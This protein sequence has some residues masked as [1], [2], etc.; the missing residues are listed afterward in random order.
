[1]HAWRARA[2]VT[3]MRTDQL[4]T[5]AC[6]MLPISDPDRSDSDVDVDAYARA[7]STAFFFLRFRSSLR[8]VKTGGALAALQSTRHAAARG[9]RATVTSMKRP[10]SSLCKRPSGGAHRPARRRRRGRQRWR[11][12]HDPRRPGPPAHGQN[13]ARAQGALEY[14]LARSNAKPKMARV[15]RVRCVSV[16]A[17][18]CVCVCARVCV[19]VKTS[20]ALMS[21]GACECVGGV[22]P[23]CLHV[24]VRDYV[25]TRVHV[26]L[27]KSSAASSLGRC[28]RARE[29]TLLRLRGAHQMQ[30]GG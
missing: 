24:H 6:A 23:L 15:L 30:R 2:R 22:R 26:P 5:R 1:M 16:R 8:S 29:H 10:S 27:A 28:E 3:C 12:I 25:G 4:I 18:V 7:F 13:R 21:L 11:L 20:K 14:G 9:A 17:C 19:C